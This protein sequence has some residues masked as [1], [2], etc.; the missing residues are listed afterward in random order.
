MFFILGFLVFGIA[1]ADFFAAN[2]A[3]M[4]RD[5]LNLPVIAVGQLGAAAALTLIL[6]WASA[7]NVAESARIGAL[8]GL[9]T[10]IGIDFTTFGTSTIQNLNVT[11]VGPVVRAALWGVTGAAIAAIA[12]GRRA[13][14]R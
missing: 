6:R 2:S 8:V 9:L 14:G 11:L 3:R 10:G 4:A 1:L 5:P 13:P 7:S 12:G